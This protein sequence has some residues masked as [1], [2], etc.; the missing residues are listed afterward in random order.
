M[1]HDAGAVA[2]QRGGGDGPAQRQKAVLADDGP[3][4]ADLDAERD[5]LVLGHAAGGQLDVGVVDVQ[6]L[7]HGK[8]G[9]AVVGDVH[10]GEEARARLGH[11]QPAKGGEVVGAGVARADRRG[12]ARQRH[13]LV[14]GQADGRAIG[15]D[16]GVQVDDPRRHQAAARIDHVPHA[17]GGDV[18]GD[19]GDAPVPDGDVARGGQILAGIDHLS[20]LDQ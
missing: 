1:A 9:Q 3:G 13:Q 6:H 14:G 4:L 11:A 5:V 20:A 19:G 8:A 15:I 2:G 17:I 12:G 18:G 7:G 16:V 10:E